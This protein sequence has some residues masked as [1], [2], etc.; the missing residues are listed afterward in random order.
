MHLTH[1]LERPLCAALMECLLCA[2]CGADRTRITKS[3]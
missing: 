1:T 3:S 2:G